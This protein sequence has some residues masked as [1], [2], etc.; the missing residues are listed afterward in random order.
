MA[1]Y[2]Y[3]VLLLNYHHDY[4]FKYYDTEQEILFS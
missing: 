1:L 2:S 3:E 4:C